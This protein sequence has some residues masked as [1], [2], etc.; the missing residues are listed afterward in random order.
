MRISYTEKKEDMSKGKKISIIN[1]TNK[2][3]IEFKLYNKKSTNNWYE[4][5]G[6][7]K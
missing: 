7:I 2:Y 5:R 4:E 1:Y 3:N 6:E